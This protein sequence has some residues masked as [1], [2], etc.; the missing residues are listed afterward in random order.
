V[1]D[2]LPIYL[3][4]PFRSSSGQA[5]HKAAVIFLSLFYNLNNMGFK[6]SESTRHNQVRNPKISKFKLS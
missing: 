1:F 2:V 6:N 3:K 4:I 5:L